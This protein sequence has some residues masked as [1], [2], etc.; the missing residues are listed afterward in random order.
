MDL[1]IWILLKVY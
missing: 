1:D